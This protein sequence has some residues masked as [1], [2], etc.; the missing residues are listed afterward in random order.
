MGGSRTRRTGLIT[1]LLLGLSAGVTGVLAWLLAPDSAI[2]WI[3]VVGGVLGPPGLWLAWA[4]YRDDRADNADLTVEQVADQIAVAVRDQWTAEAELRRLNDPYALPVRWQPADPGLVQDWASL[5]R[6]AT[7]GGAGWPSPP[8]AGTWAA[9][10]AGLAGSD[11]ELIEALD[12]VPT[13][14]LV[15]LGEPGAGKTILLVRLVLALLAR[16]GPAEP[17]PVLVPLAS[18]N[19]TGQHLYDWLETRLIADHPGLGDPA[20]GPG[21]LSRGRALLNAGLIVAVLD[22][23]DEIPET[24]RGGAIA[25]INEALRPGQRLVLAARSRPYQAAVRPAGGIEVRLTG[26]AGVELCPL[27]AAAITDY[28]HASAGGPAAAARWDPVLAT[29]TA[30]APP[31]VAQ[32]LT[33]PLMTTLAR[34]IYNPRPGEA[35]TAVPRRPLEL[36]N[37][38]LFPTRS[39]VEEHLFDAFIPAAY[40]PHPDPARRCPWP[41]A[42][43]ERWLV[44]LARH[45][46]HNLHGTPDL[47]WWQLPTCLTTPA[48]A[49]PARGRAPGR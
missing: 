26:A 16:R 1:L 9:G 7:A 32:A 6:L 42:D 25:R 31:P 41:A 23:L 33:T 10:P 11:N 34:T 13:G 4:S 38:G 27:D 21:G 30:S 28:L 35:L 48:L 44:F 37:P 20:P 43:A 40:R 15:V 47:A 5:V 45:L 49:S 19:P 2:A 46:D 36:L 22:G 3:G 8:P 14:R 24:V 12:R 29:L 18:W 17:V 39:A